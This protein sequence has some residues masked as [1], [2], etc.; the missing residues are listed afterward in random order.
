[1]PVMLA[2]TMIAAIGAGI[3]ILLDMHTSTGLSTTYMIVWGIGSGLGANLPFTALQAV[4]RSVLIDSL[5][6]GLC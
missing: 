5:V 2:G 4:L 6:I 3:M 1:M